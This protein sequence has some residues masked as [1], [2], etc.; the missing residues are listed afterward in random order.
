MVDVTRVY[1]GEYALESHKGLA[2]VR[3]TGDEWALYEL[4]EGSYDAYDEEYVNHFRTLREAK[5]YWGSRTR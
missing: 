3:K 1:P 4:V 5:E 2:V